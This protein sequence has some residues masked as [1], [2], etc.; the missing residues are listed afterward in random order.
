MVIFD[1]LLLLWQL[2]VPGKATS[3]AN[4]S[5]A[6]RTLSAA[7]SYLTEVEPTG[8]NEAAGL[9]SQ[10]TKTPWFPVSLNFIEP[11]SQFTEVNKSANMEMILRCFSLCW[12]LK[13]QSSTCVNFFTLEINK[14]DRSGINW[15]SLTAIHVIVLWEIRKLRL[16]NKK[17]KRN[18]FYFKKYNGTI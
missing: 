15:T 1:Q 14:I 16:V 18:K 17:K 4:V 13:E 2:H 5:L 9:R 7:Q 3:G 6:K 11:K 12:N 8:T 10:G